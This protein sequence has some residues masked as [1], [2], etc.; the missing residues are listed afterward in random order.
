MSM[1]MFVK[2]AKK[3]TLEEAFQEA[4]KVEKNILNLKFNHGAEPSKDKGKTKATMSKPSKEM[5][6]STP[7]IWKLSREL[8]KKLSNELI[9]LKKTDGEGSSN[10]TKFFRFPPKK[11]KITTPNQ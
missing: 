3:Y 6:D 5:K 8:S 10:S 9:D 1:E 2:N 11:D 4:L 7:W